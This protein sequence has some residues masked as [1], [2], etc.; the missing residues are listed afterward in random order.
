M[1]SGLESGGKNFNSLKLVIFNFYAQ[2]VCALDF[3]R[4]PLL[5]EIL[6]TLPEITESIT[7]FLEITLQLKSEISVSCYLILENC[8]Y[9]DIK[10]CSVDT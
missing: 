7:Y 2:A 4:G 8:V 9:F 5:V 1:C 3:S 6:H 10:P